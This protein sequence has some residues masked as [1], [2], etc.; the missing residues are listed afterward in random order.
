MHPQADEMIAEILQY[1]ADGLKL[2]S[3]EADCIYAG[4]MIDTNKSL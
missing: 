4:I 2:R 3:I 1:F